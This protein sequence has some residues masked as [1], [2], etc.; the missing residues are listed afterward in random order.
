M[1]ALSFTDEQLDALLRAATPIPPADRTAFL[2]EIAAKLDGKTIGDGVVFRVIREIQGHYLDPPQKAR[3][4]LA[5][6][7]ARLQWVLGCPLQSRHPARC[8]EGSAGSCPGPPL[9]KR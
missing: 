5:G 3:T 6:L 4:R 1:Q 7:S 2:E 9:S 8:L